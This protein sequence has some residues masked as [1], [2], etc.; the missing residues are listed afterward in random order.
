MTELSK[1]MKKE[2][3]TYIEQEMD[4]G[5]TLTSVRSALL[6]AGHH[7]DLIDAIITLLKKHNMDFSKV[8]EE[9]IHYPPLQKTIYYDLVNSIVKYTEDQLSRGYS[10]EEIKERL[11]AYGH[12]HDTVEAAIKTVQGDDPLAKIPKDE[13]QFFKK[14]APA[15]TFFILLAGLLVFLLYIAIA[16]GTEVQII[17]L[18]FS[19]A[20]L[21][22]VFSR[23]AL[24]YLTPRFMV[25]LIPILFT[26]GFYYLTTTQKS[27]LVENLQIPELT[28]L[29][30]GIS[31]V[32]VGILYV[33]LP[34]ATP[35]HKKPKPENIQGKKQENKKQGSPLANEQKTVAPLAQPRLYKM[36]ASGR[37]PVLP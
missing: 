3:A 15:L 29:N 4:K 14:M 16:T 23:A 11:Y 25:W 19:P 37:D 36:S 9:P 31:L 28:G 18:A 26:G 12:R 32:L 33:L 27:A 30:F 10:L 34:A 21:S 22:L 35:I 8:L 1:F 7:K 24:A 2:L 17:L 6:R 5:H 20:I 13:T